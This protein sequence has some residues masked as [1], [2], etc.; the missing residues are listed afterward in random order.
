[1]CIPA[2]GKRNKVLTQFQIKGTKVRARG[3]YLVG[4]ARSQ[5]EAK[6]AKTDAGKKSSSPK[7]RKAKAAK[8]R[9]KG[10]MKPSANAKGTSRE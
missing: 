4:N 8:E 3:L 7:R 9:K 10:K 2:G 6:L 1:M 5:I